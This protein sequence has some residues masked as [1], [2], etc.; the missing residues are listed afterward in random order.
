[1]EQVQFNFSMFRM[2]SRIPDLAV[3]I[4]TVMNK[5][6]QTDYPVLSEIQRRWS[7]YAFDP[8]AVEEEK[9]QRIFEAARWAASSYNEQPWRYIVAQASQPEQFRKLASVLVPQNNWAENVPVLAMSVAKMSFTKSGMENRVAL[10]DVGA[11]SAQLSL[12]AVA[13]GLMVHQMAG[14][15]TQRAKEIYGIQAGYEP[16]AMLA[17]GYEGNHDEI[18]EALQERE[19]APRGRN[20]HSAFVFFG[21]WPIS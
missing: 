10:H 15:D 18:P 7:P 5:T 8:R 11:A 6:A 21:T 12:Q 16:V 17:I 3:R 13:E 19:N 20:P 4:H 9:L 1:M 2:M 14:F